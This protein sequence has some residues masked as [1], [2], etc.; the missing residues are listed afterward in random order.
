MVMGKPSICERWSPK[1]REESSYQPDYSETPGPFIGNIHLE[2]WSTVSTRIWWLKLSFWSHFGCD[3]FLLLPPICS[4]GPLIAIKKIE[5]LFLVHFPRFSENNL[6]PTSTK[7][8][9]GHDLLWAP[10]NRLLVPWKRFSF[11][12]RCFFMISM[13][14]QCVWIKF[15]KVYIYVREDLML[16]V[17]L[18]FGDSIILGWERHESYLAH[19]WKRNIE[20]NP[21]F[22]QPKWKSGE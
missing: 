15:N 17:V 4:F 7:M 22:V 12:G 19:E 2:V 11:P 18:C 1:G 6:L 21:S 20:K 9:L 8:R 13:K 3:L 14:H 5:F 16:I 10:P